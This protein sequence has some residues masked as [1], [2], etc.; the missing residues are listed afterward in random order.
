MWNNST[1]VWIYVELFHMGNKNVIQHFSIPHVCG[2]IDRIGLQSGFNR[3]F[4]DMRPALEIC[5][6][7]EISDIEIVANILHPQINLLF[8]KVKVTHPTLLS[9]FSEQAEAES[10]EEPD[11]SPKPRVGE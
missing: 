8:N 3:A 4:S 10:S 6:W 2:F 7:S 11:L 1:H 5:V 9:I